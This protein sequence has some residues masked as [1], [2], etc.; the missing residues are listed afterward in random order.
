MTRKPSPPASPPSGTEHIIGEAFD[1]ADQ[2][3]LI[4]NRVFLDDENLPEAERVA[5]LQEVFH[6]NIRLKQ[7]ERLAKLLAPVGTGHSPPHVLIYGPTGTG[8]SVTCLHFLSAMR[9]LCVSK[10]IPF[11]YFHLDL[12][13]PRTCFGAFNELAIALDGS[14]RRYRKGIAL[15]EMQEHVIA[16]LNRL[17]GVIS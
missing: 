12:T 15:T 1:T 8:K 11:Q 14:T 10:N 13:T 4:L 7:I 5:V 9:T 16:T 6:R 2:R 17:Q 3:R